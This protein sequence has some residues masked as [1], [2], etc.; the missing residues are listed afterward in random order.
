MNGPPPAK[1]HSISAVPMPQQTQQQQQTA[2][3]LAHPL[4]SLPMLQGALN[5]QFAA[6]HAQAQLNGMN[7]PGQ[8]PSVLQLP[9]IPPSFVATAQARPNGQEVNGLNAGIQNAQM[10][11]LPGECIQ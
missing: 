8:A 5:P 3:G 1:R 10:L 2:A 11:G 6:A 7:K 4:A 9:T